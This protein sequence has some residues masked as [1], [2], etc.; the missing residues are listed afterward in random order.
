MRT[1]TIFDVHHR[2]WKTNQPTNYEKKIPAI[3][4]SISWPTQKFKKKE[5]T[6][7]FVK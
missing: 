4:S 2:I 3:L 5:Q 1:T 6:E 7:H